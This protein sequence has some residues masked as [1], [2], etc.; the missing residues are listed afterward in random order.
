MKISSLHFLIFSISI[1]VLMLVN[2]TNTKPLVIYS[3]N[4]SSQLIHKTSLYVKKITKIEKPQKPSF[5]EEASK[6]KLVQKQAESK[7]LSESEMASIE[8]QKSSGSDSQKAHYIDQVRRLIMKNK[9]YPRIAQKLKQEGVVEIYFEIAKTNKISK[10]EIKKASSFE[11]LNKAALEAV[12]GLELG[13]LEFPKDIKAQSLEIE[14]P[15]QFEL[16]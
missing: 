12:E 15:M 7:K 5:N 11:S 13:H 14:L 10:L 2:F 4:T 8:S 3:K 9:K 1:H 6:N 16:L